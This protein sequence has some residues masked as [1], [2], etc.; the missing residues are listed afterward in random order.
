MT[1]ILHH[2][3]QQSNLIPSKLLSRA[4]CLPHTAFSTRAQSDIR[5][6]LSLTASAAKVSDNSIKAS[7]AVKAEARVEVK[8]EVLRSEEHCGGYYQQQQCYHRE[9]ID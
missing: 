3:I 2:N 6:V 7:T 1:P 8:A 5:A 9:E 4:N